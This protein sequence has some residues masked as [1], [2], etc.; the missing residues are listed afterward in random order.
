MRFWFF[1]LIGFLGL[2]VGPVL[3]QNMAGNC[4]A[5]ALSRVK[6]HRVAAGESLE[7]IGRQYN[8]TPATLVG[9][10]PGLRNGGLR[11]GEV[12]L[13]PPFNG[14]QV[15]TNPGTS[16]KS[17]AEIYNVRADVLFEVNGCVEPQEVV[18][19]P[20]VNSSQNNR[21]VQRA[22]EV[23]AGVISGY[24]LPQKAPVLLGYGLQF[25]PLRNIQGF[26]AGVDLEAKEGTAVL[27]AGEGIIAFAG[28]QGN[29]GN[30]IVINHAS[31][32]QTRYAHLASISVRVGEQ[33]NRGQVLGTVGKTGIPDIT[34]SHL[35]FEVRSSS[36]MG[37]V[38]EDP[39][40]YFKDGPVGVRSF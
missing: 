4:P 21:E 17:L 31:G 9:M 25:M 34:A 6:S 37:W 38:A 23:A 30:L 13:I 40:N 36:Q 16:W 18:F 29:Y 1:V 20:G 26:H 33:V 3:A 11:V 14:R 24:P 28:M 19:I 22:V 32:K 35:H 7:S 12:I 39:Q 15:A 5:P 2:E 10:N 27:A 8:L